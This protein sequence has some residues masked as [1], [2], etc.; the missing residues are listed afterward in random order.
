MAKSKVSSKAHR[1][2]RINH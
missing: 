1:G 2:K